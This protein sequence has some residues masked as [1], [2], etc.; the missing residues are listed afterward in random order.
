MASGR[1]MPA[2]VVDCWM[3]IAN[4]N[5]KMLYIPNPETNWNT[6]PVLI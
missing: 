6:Q 5:R 1:E 2:E 4:S 3:V